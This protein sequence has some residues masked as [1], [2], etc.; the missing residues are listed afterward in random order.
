MAIASSIAD[1][2]ARLSGF[3]LAFRLPDWLLH[4]LQDKLVLLLNHVLG[5]EPAATERLR[6][7]QGQC[8]QVSWRDYRLQ[9]LITPAGLL[10]RAE[11][12]VAADLHLHIN[13]DQPLS[14]LQTLAKG[15]KPTMRIDGDVML[16][17]DIN[18]LVDH[19]R[20]DIEADLARILGDAP[21]HLLVDGVQRMVHALRQF[22]G[23][24]R[25]PGSANAE[26][27]A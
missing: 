17:A 11:A 26:S 23:S 20:W 8:I 9:W 2:S 4:E 15:E 5:Q 7:Q 25:R 16:A 24:V 21:A 6:R 12:D 19:V 3:M 10:T 1:V 18:W 14:L 22:A 27:A 13:Q